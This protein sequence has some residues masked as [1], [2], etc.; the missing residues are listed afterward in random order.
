[1]LV[2]DA[3]A[4]CGLTLP[5]E[6]LFPLWD[7]GGIDG[8]VLFAPVEEVY[9]RYDRWFIDSEYYRESRVKVH[10]YLESLLSDYIFAYWF[11]WNDFKLPRDNF[12]GIKWHRHDDEPEYRYKTEECEKFIEYICSRQLPVIVE[13]E[14]QNTLE[15]V[16]RINGRTVV[17]IPHFG[18]LNGG[19][20]RLKKAGL[21]E[22][23]SVYVDT[24]LAGRHEMAD[25]AADYGVDRIIFGSDFPFGSPARERSKVEQVFSGRDRKKVLAENIL[26]LL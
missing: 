18:M 1:M 6:E 11:V 8:G 4:H 24:A 10:D 14:F 21:F 22:N 26:S 17:I 13:E 16:E 5:W 19:Y 20:S 12:K 23:S 15:L 2:L 7:D 9:D 25:F 3:H